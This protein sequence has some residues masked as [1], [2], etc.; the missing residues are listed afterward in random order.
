MPL[1]V[2]WKGNRK[3]VIPKGKLTKELKIEIR[4]WYF[5]VLYESRHE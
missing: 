2:K 1:S 3:E 5:V 4:S